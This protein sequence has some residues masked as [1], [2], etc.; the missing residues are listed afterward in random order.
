MTAHMLRDSA[1][2]AYR[3]CARCVMDTTDVD[4]VFDAGGRCN[5]CIMVE[6]EIEHHW[7]P[8]QRGEA[9]LRGI[10]AAIKEF[11]KGKQYD[12]IIGLSGGVDS[13]Y[14]AVKAVEWG[15]KP[16][17]VHVD[18]GW[19]SELAVKNIDRIVTRL[20]LDLHTHVID[21]EEAKDLQLA[22]LRSN[23][24]NQDCPQEHAFFGAL[25]TYAVE[26][27]IRWVIS[28][29]NWQTESILPISW[30]YEPM[31]HRHF[32]AVHRQFGSRKLK[33]FPLVNFF[34]FHVYYPHVKNMT[35][36]EPLNYMPYTKK[37][38][39]E[40]LEKNYGWR[41]YGGKHY[42][43]RWTR[44]FQSYYLPTKFGYD[45]RKAHLS[46]QIVAGEITRGEALSELEK[47]L[48]TENELAEDK[49]FVAKK[50]GLSLAELDA[51]VA[52]PP[53]HYS[54]FPNSEARYLRLLAA[55]AFLRD[56]KYRLRG[57]A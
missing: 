12:S 24:A 49:A 17:A 8:L 36:V 47:P 50:L 19:N 7:L 21:W 28:G 15:L 6:S 11:G 22:Y 33:S 43:S 9:E 55:Q 35:V 44:F 31:D 45:K 32:T 48:Y 10:I 1:E 56:V 3:M 26:N 40:Y 2:R 52:A 46:S 14:L 41:Y 16:L 57:G 25:Y 4:I 27:G 29:T 54:E 13:S 30:G 39:I 23:L 42:E 37:A 5:Y 53:R 34:K 18:A 51:L 38:A 20:G